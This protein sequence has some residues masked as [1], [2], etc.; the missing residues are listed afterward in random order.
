MAVSR[1]EFTEEG[2]EVSRLV[3]GVWRMAEWQM[4]SQQIADWVKGCLDVGITTFDHADIY[5]SYTCEKLFGDALAGKS[6]LRQKMELVTKC[7]IKLVSL[8]RPQHRL[9]SYDTSKVHII[10]SAEQSLKNLGTDYIDLLLIHRPDPLLDADEVAEA[11]T[12][13][14]ESGKVLHFGVSNF[15]NPQF[16]LLDSRLNEFDLITNQIELSVLYLD[17]LHDGTLDFLQ[18]MEIKPMIWS[19][20]GGGSLFTG[21]DERSQRLRA[22]L[23][24]VGEELGGAGLDQVALAWLLMLP[25]Q[26]IPVLGTGQLERIRAAAQAEQF[27]L[28]REQW[29]M[30]WEASMGHEVP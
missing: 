14:W 8:N 7:G 20:L 27:H 16:S 9:H 19:P 2:L 29:F 12:E 3:A 11:M 28:S 13:L 24:R 17:P 5:G 18:M 10:A 30:I 22:V 26:P 15:T 25:S 4:N 1:I 6:Y 23:G 21:Q